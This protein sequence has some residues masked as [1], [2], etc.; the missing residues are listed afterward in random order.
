MEAID[1]PAALNKALADMKA[2]IEG[3]KTETEKIGLI[4]RLVPELQTRLDAIQT[5]HVESQA[6]VPNGTDADVTRQ[7]WNPGVNRENIKSCADSGVVDLRDS[8]PVALTEKNRYVGNDAGVVRMLGG[9]ENGYWE[10]GLLDDP[11]PTSEWQAVLQSKV[12]DAGMVRSLR[13]R[14]GAESTQFK[15]MQRGIIAHLRRGPASIAKMFSANA[16]EGG[17]WIVTLPLSTLERLV[18]IPRILEGQFQDIQIS[19]KSMQ[20]PFL[21]RGVQPFQH[22]TPTAGDTNPAQYPKSVPATDYRTLTAP[23]FAVSIPI[24]N[25]AI[26]DVVILDSLSILQQL[27]G[28]ALVD[29][30]EDAYINGDTA[31]SHFHTAIATWT[32][33]GRWGITG[34]PVDHRKSMIGLIARADD[35]SATTDGSAA[36]TIADNIAAKAQLTTPHGVTDL[37]YLTSPAHYL[38]KIVT[39]TN[40]LTVDKFG[41]NATIHTGQVASIGGSPLFLSQFMSEELNASGVY[42]GVTSTYTGM[43][44]VAKNRFRNI[45]RRSLRVAVEV[46][47]REGVT[48]IVLT[49][50]RGLG[51]IDPAASVKN[52]FYRYKLAKT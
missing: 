1:S 6:H 23:T 47:E 28:E 13:G 37:F 39:D 12:N 10:D 22:G 32:S 3:T 46:V 17:D 48:Y 11:K 38:A 27:A 34:S 30:R 14:H 20:L 4:A 50:R 9:I 31:A 29:G 42:D 40:V 49:E 44:I 7:F 51:T 8:R 33:G 52:V 36:Q 45:H 43:L 24:E 5:A 25:D 19:T 41:P 16:T 35:V 2:A 15:A 26:E 21:T 18:E